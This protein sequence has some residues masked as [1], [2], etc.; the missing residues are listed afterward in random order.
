[1][2]DQDNDSQAGPS[3]QPGD[4]PDSGSESEAELLW[5]VEEQCK[6]VGQERKGP[7]QA[8]KEQLAR[9]LAEMKALTVTPLSAP[10]QRSAKVKAGSLRRHVNVNNKVKA[11]RGDGIQ[12]NINKKSPRRETIK[13]RRTVNDLRALNEL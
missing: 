2:A 1:M 12:R 5:T 9:E 13:N 3:N 6:Q 8:E 7:M 4:A 11:V 10:K